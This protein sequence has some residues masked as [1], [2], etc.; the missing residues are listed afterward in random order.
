VNK[1]CRFKIFRYVFSIYKI[2]LGL[3]FNGYA[4]L[5]CCGEIIAIRV[6]NFF[7]EFT[8]RGVQNGTTIVVVVRN[9]G[10]TA[11]RTLYCILLL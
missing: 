3:G 2:E 5:F 10:L 1:F 6:T 11:R 7:I 8:S 4:Y 9:L